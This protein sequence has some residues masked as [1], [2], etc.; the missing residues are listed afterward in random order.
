MKWRWWKTIKLH[1]RILTRWNSVNRNVYW[2]VIKNEHA[3]EVNKSDP[4]GEAA[5]FQ[6]QFCGN[7]INNFQP[8]RTAERVRERRS[9]KNCLGVFGFSNAI[10]M[11]FISFH[12]ISSL[13]LIFFSSLF[14]HSFTL[15]ICQLSNCVCV[16]VNVWFKCSFQMKEKKLFE[17]NWK[18][19]SIRRCMNS[20]NVLCWH[21][22][23]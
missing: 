19:L 12:S 13:R 18:Q 10:D 22:Y 15:S 1:C 3:I 14:C 11:Q 9:E 17:K 4:N 16:S 6:L 8:T 2:Y 5:N 7:F 21:E 20:V 23:N